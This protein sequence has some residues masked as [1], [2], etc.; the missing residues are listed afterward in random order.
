MQIF[1]KLLKIF[2]KSLMSTFLLNVSLN[3]NF[4]LEWNSCIKFCLMFPPRTKILESLL[5]QLYITVN[6]TRGVQYLNERK[7][8]MHFYVIILILM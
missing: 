8:G 6:C 5:V 4:G 7:M 3:R 2:Q 1:N